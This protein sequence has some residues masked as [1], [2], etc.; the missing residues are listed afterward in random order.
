VRRFGTRNVARWFMEQDKQAAQSE[1]TH[2]EGP[3]TVP[4]VGRV[5]INFTENEVPL[6]SQNK[7]A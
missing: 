4:T 5:Y 2:D 6:A 7:H 1:I 3:S